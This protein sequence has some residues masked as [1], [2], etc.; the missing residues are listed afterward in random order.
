ME[1]RDGSIGQQAFVQ[2][3]DRHLPYW[4]LGLGWVLLGLALLVLA[5]WLDVRDARVSFERQAAALHEDVLQKL[6]VNEV[7][8]AG[9]AA[10]YAVSG[11][12]A[13]AEVAGY[14][15]DMLARYPHIHTMAVQSY[16]PVEPAPGL[17][18]TSLPKIRVAMERALVAGEAVASSPFELTDGQLAYA[19][20]QPIGRRQSTDDGP[21][22]TAY[23]SMPGSC[24]RYQR[25]AG[26]RVQ[27]CLQR[28][29]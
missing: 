6:R 5:L 26:N 25:T 8:L 12:V 19:L 16:P 18:E 21:G 23:G 7:V 4:R 24:P 22:Q 20:V 13:R 15:Q 1:H 9:L 28:D 17:T 14:M 3:D 2:P 11:D 27:S 10:H 29:Q